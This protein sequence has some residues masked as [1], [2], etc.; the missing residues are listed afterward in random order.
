[1]RILVDTNILL[2]VLLARKPFVDF[3][4]EILR[5]VEKGRVEGFVTANSI[6]DIIYIIRKYISDRDVRENAVKTIVNIFDIAPA[7]KKDIL[8][9]FEMGFSDYEDALQARCALKINADYIITRD[10][11]GFIKSKVKP[12]SPHEFI[13]ILEKLEN[14]N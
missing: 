9:A 4:S 5:L 8:K 6:V 1:M 14:G 10:N 7:T 3:S 2:D 13:K 12:V 11:D